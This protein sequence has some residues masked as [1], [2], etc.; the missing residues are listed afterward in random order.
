[1][2]TFMALGVRTAGERLPSVEIVF[3]RTI[4]QLLLIFPLVVRSGLSGLHTNRVRLHA[5]RVLLAA[6]TVQATFYAFTKMPL[7]DVTAISFSRSLFL[8]ILAI[9]VLKESVGKHR[10]SATIIGFVGVL[11]IVQPGAGS[12]QI[13]AIAALLAAFLSAAMSITVRL[14]SST[15]QNVQIMLFPALFTLVISA[16]VSAALWQAPTS[17][18]IATIGAAAIA[19]FIGQWCMIEGFRAGETSA[20]APINYLRILFAGAL[21][22]LFFNEIPGITTIIGASII[23]AATLYTLHRESIAGKQ[24]RQ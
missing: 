2:F 17:V 5:L 22:Y 23:V 12:L 6:M 4:F 19:G 8:T 20:L 24:P 3:F 13:A 10:W 16:P 11:F 1:M 9:V 21:G 18:E 7:A 15:E 14:L